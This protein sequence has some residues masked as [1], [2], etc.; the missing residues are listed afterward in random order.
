[1]TDLR[2]I[3]EIVYFITAG[4]ILLIIVSLG[5]WQLKIA[6]D[7]ARM[8]AKRESYKLAADQCSYYMSQIIPL[9]N[10]LNEAIAKNNVTFFKKAIV[11]IEGN[12]ISVKF[13]SNKEDI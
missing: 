6:K 10:K 8:T 3:L 12:A 5:L 1:M 11:Q 9:Q 13:N 2:N 4:P 7:N